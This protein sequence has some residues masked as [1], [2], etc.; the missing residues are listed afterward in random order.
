MFLLQTEGEVINLQCGYR[1]LDNTVSFEF[2][3]TY[4]C[5]HMCM[6]VCMY[7]CIW[8]KQTDRFMRDIYTVGCFSAVRSLVRSNLYIVG[9]VGLGLLIFQAINIMLAGGLASDIHKEKK[10]IKAQKELRKMQEEG[11]GL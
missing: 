4:E 5:I 2:F 8:C 1:R 3:L 10:I 9:G 11:A 7:V 6:H